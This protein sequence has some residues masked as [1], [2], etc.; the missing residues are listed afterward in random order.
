MTVV[1]RLARAAI[2]MCLALASCTEIG[3]MVAVAPG[4]GKSA[5]EYG[6]DRRECMAQ[7]DRELQPV[8]DAGMLHDRTTGE[9][10]AGNA[11]IQAAYDRSYGSCM[12]ARG[13]L[14]PAPAVPLPGA[15]M[16]PTP[17]LAV[18]MPTWDA[19][20]LPVLSDADSNA[21]RASIAPE[22]HTLLAACPGETIA[23]AAYDPILAPGVTAR[24][25]ALTQPNGGGCLGHIGE[26]DFLVARRHD[27][28]WRT[29][30]SAE[31]GSLGIRPAGHGGYREVELRSFGTCVYGYRWNGLEFYPADAHDCTLP[32]PVEPGRDADA[33]RER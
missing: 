20:N 15:P 26:A 33:V 6:Q 28:T 23:V 8:A 24:L 16:P 14:V 2:P 12:A 29:L 7:T 31:P 9:M 25:L 13:N 18:P 19:S 5:P 1:R 17:E 10:A 4:A 11:R 22:V 32:A 3:P 27:G 30:L 21:A